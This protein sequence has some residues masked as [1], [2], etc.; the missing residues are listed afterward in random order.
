MNRF[1]NNII[2]PIFIK[3]NIKTIIEIGIDKGKNTTKLI[4]YC[5]M[6][7]GKLISIDPK[8]VINVNLLEEKYKFFRC[9][10]DLSLNALP[11][12]KNFDAVLIDGD[13]NWYTVFNELKIIEKNSL[14]YKKFPLVF[15]HDTEWP[16][17]RRDMYY[18]PETIPSNFRKPYAK[19]GI[20]AGQSELK[21]PKRELGKKLINSHLNNALFEGGE[22]NGVLT[23]IED[24]IKS[25]SVPLSFCK[26]P[27][28]NGLGILFQKNRQLESFIEGLTKTLKQ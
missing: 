7:G 19:K 15:L 27:T 28:N 8:P 12:I 21:D 22:K 3:E 24:F 16:Y 23:A 5:L 14:I 26:I 13:H 4:D 1:W 2:K 9:I 11:T 25:S 18:L 20:I 6:N 10:K 17:A